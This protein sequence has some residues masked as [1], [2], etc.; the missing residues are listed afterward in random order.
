M[1]YQLRT[2]IK[3]AGLGSK[4]IRDSTVVSRVAM[5]VMV[6]MV[7]VTAVWVAKV[8]DMAAKEEGMALERTR[9][10]D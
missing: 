10:T 6:A 7:V 2:S 3:E 4:R 5:V 1:A 8:V 9:C